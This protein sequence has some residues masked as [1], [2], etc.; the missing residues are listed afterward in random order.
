M[1]K[2]IRLT[3]GQLKQLIGE[4]I[5]SVLK[6]DTLNE[7]FGLSEKDK[8][9][10]KIKQVLH[11]L[12]IGSIKYKDLIFN[13][14]SDKEHQ[15]RVCRREVDSAFMSA[16]HLKELIPEILEYKG[17]RAI[18]KYTSIPIQFSRG[19]EITYD[20]IEDVV[21]TKIKEYLSQKYNMNIK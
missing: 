18:S 20:N 5:K 8:L 3:E 10:K 9:K 4:T 21:N 11:E 15:E 14:I 19:G 1:K 7:L 6:E 2:T 17:T 13:T 12:E 16:R